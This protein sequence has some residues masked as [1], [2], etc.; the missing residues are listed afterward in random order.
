MGIL[1]PVVGC[2]SDRYNSI[3]IG[4][5]AFVTLGG[6]SQ[7]GR[8]TYHMPIVGGIARCFRDFVALAMATHSA[9]G[10][11]LCPVHGLART[12]CLAVLVNAP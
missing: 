10:F 11:E 8:W 3:I 6:G 5:Q 2:Q 7:L 9:S 12:P 4:V 1:W